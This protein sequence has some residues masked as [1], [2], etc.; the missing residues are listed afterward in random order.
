MDVNVYGCNAGIGGV[1]HLDRR[2]KLTP[3]ERDRYELLQE[4]EKAER[5]M[6][7]KRFKG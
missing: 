6:Q 2:R 1:N 7:N 3:D 5:M 4:V